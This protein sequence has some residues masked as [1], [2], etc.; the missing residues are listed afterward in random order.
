MCNC[1]THAVKQL[2]EQGVGY[3]IERP[4][5]GSSIRAIKTK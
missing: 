4:E 3:N 2:Q 1:P 5:L